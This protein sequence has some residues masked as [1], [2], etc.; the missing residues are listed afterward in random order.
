MRNLGQSLPFSDSSLVIAQCFLLLSRSQSSYHPFVQCPQSHREWVQSFWV[1]Q[2]LQQC[3][4]P[5][6]TLLDGMAPESPDWYIAC[7]FPTSEKIVGLEKIP[8]VR[9]ERLGFLLRVLFLVTGWL[10]TVFLAFLNFE[11]FLLESINIY[12]AR[13]RLWGIYRP[14]CKSSQPSCVQDAKWKG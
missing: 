10:L 13:A 1:A 4:V 12:W 5:E 8:G 3:L 14:C 11:L 2:A 9:T 7:S 6:S